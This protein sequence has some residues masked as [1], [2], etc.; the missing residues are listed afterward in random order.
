[1]KAKH[2]FFVILFVSGVISIT[3]CTLGKDFRST[4]GKPVDTIVPETSNSGQVEYR[5]PAARV[6]ELHFG[7][8]NM[9]DSEKLLGT[10]TSRWSENPVDWG[11]ESRKSI[12]IVSI[13]EVTDEVI[14]EAY[15]VGGMGSINGTSGDNLKVYY[16][17]FEAVYSTGFEGS[18]R[19]ETEAWWYYVIRDNEESDWLIDDFGL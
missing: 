6:I 3:G 5:D 4:S 18:D 7:Y 1:M 12:K 19:T 11:F 17:C 15:L 2:L 14:R 16:V 8:L 10:L 9:E 13:S